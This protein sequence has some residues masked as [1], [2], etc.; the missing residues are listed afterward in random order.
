MLIYNMQAI[1]HA[2]RRA[3]THSSRTHIEFSI[4][5]YKT[6]SKKLRLHLS[7]ARSLSRSLFRV[8]CL[9]EVLF[10]THTLSLSCCLSLSRC[11]LGICT[12]PSR[13][14]TASVRNKKGIFF[15][16]S[17]TC[18][19]PHEKYLYREPKALR[20]VNGVFSD[21]STYYMFLRKFLYVVLHL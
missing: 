20:P 12:N 6:G 4:F 14:S 8:S 16:A 18:Y 7:L 3:H 13:S 10:C 9:P 11:W 19:E 1:A 2:V 17:C 15:S 21:H 5:F